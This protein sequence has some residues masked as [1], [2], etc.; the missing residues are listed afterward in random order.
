MF[1]FPAIA[2]PLHYQIE[3]NVLNTKMLDQLDLLL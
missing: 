2:F 1:A 3:K